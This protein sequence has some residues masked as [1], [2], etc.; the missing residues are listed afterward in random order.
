M[1][2]HTRTPQANVEN[3]AE[4]A[5]CIRWAG[6]T[7]HRREVTTSGWSPCCCTIGELQ[8]PLWDPALSVCTENRTVG[9]PLDESLQ[10]LSASTA[11]DCG[12][13]CWARLH[14]HPVLCMDQ[15]GWRNCRC[16][17]TRSCG[18][19]SE[20]IGQDAPIMLRPRH[21]AAWP[22]ELQ[23]LTQLLSRMR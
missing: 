1:P 3:I 13:T 4:I 15:T 10:L 11:P 20:D 7:V 18:A 23:G 21:S 12:R 5:Q 2:T 22:E 9:D 16:I 17:S 6:C 8:G 14:N 19:S